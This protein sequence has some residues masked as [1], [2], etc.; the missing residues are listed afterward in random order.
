MLNQLKDE[1]LKQAQTILLYFFNYIIDILHV[2]WFKDF[3]FWWNFLKYMP[4]QCES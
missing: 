1:K 2:L 4:L 3:P